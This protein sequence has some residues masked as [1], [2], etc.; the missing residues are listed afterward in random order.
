MADY[1]SREFWFPWALAIL[2]LSA[3]VFS[4]WRAINFD[5]F[6]SRSASP[7]DFF[8]LSG[9]VFYLVIMTKKYGVGYLL[10]QIFSLWYFLLPIALMV[11]LYDDRSALNNIAPSFT[12]YLLFGLIAY[13][14]MPYLI[15]FK[16]SEKK[17]LVHLMHYIVIMSVFILI[18]YAITRFYPL[19]TFM[20][21]E[22]TPALNF[23][24][25]SPNQAALFV[26]LNFFLGLGVILALRK[27]YFLYFFV[28][29]MV[30]ATFQTGSRSMAI[31]L[32][33]G[34]LTFILLVL[35][36][37]IYSKKCPWRELLNF[38]IGVVLA[39][40]TLFLTLDTQSKRAISIFDSIFSNVAFEKI[41]P[42]RYRVNKLWKWSDVREAE[43]KVELREGAHNAYLDIRLNWGKLSLIS[44][45]IF[46]LALFFSL[47]SL[48]WHKRRSTNYPLYGALLIGSGVVIGA[49]YVNPLLH[50]KFIW[51][52][53]GV[54]ISFLLNKYSTYNHIGSRI[55]V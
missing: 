42:Y 47:M 39:V 29:V 44:F 22:G 30:L 50:L 52:F 3:L 55:I 11:F 17:I 13:M 26:V 14:L 27:F 24:Y 12:R 19:K 36:Q 35:F 7:I 23:P 33:A 18:V 32:V 41:D 37:W 38:L 46:L 2:I 45:I 4:E 40:F 9:G 8:I 1:K 34:V 48:L 15:F 54:S 20:Y 31:L 6:G 43:P 28:P 49:I 21:G 16:Y 51:I 53:F 10:R 5:L 25:G